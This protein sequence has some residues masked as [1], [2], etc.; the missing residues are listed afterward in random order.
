[1]VVVVKPLALLDFLGCQLAHACQCPRVLLYIEKCGLLGL[2]ANM[3]LLRRRQLEDYIPGQLRPDR[4]ME[5]FIERLHHE[6]FLRKIDGVSESNKRY[7]NK[8][9][10]QVQTVLTTYRCIQKKQFQLANVTHRFG[11]LKSRSGSLRG[12]CSP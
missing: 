7:I 1:M 10:P 5:K 6:E 8:S 3:D 12:R 11:S 4:Q 9:A 2:L